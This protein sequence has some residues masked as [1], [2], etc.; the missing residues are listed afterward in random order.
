MVMLIVKRWSDI[1]VQKHIAG[2]HAGRTNLEIKNSG[3][4]IDDL[5]FT[6]NT[7]NRRPSLLL[8]HQPTPT[9]TSTQPTIFMAVETLSSIVADISANN[10][11]Q[12][13]TVLVYCLAV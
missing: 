10:L 7:S 3:G 5:T 8:L 1:P 13:K 4:G 6:I 11:Q 2:Y 12:V 9:Q